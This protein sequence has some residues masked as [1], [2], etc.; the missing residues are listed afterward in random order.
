[1]EGNKKEREKV[2]EF[3][4][5]TYENVRDEKQPTEDN[6][7]DDYEEVDDGM[8]AVPMRNQQRTDRPNTDERKEPPN[9]P[10]KIEEARLRHKLKWFFSNPCQRCTYQGNTCYARVPVK[11]IVQIFKVFFISTQLMLFGTDR[12]GFVDY[13]DRH[14]LALKRL[15]LKSWITNYET[16]PYPPAVGVYGIYDINDLL[17]HIDFAVKQFYNATDVGMGSLYFIYNNEKVVPIKV[18]LTYYKERHYFP[19]ETFYLDP[20]ELKDC[21]NVLPMWETDSDNVTETNADNSTYDIAAFSEKLKQ[22]DSLKE[23]LLEVS[24]EFSYKSARLFRSIDHCYKI[25]GQI[26]IDNTDRNGQAL[27]DLVTQTAENPCSGEVDYSSPQFIQYVAIAAV[28][29]VL[30]LA[31]LF[32]SIGSIYKAVIL[33][34]ETNAFFVKY[35]HM[36]LTTSDRLEFVKFWDIVIVLNDILTISGTALKLWLEKRRTSNLTEM[37]DYCSVLLGVGCLLVWVGLVRYLTFLPKF[38]LL[39][40]TLKKSI[41]HVLRYMVCVMLLFFGFTMCGWIILGP[42]HIKF[43]TMDST[44]EC[45]F[46]I[47]QGDEMFVT[48][49]AVAGSSN[50]IWWISRLYFYIY[51]ALFTAVALNLFI[52]ILSDTYDTIKVYLCFQIN[53]SDTMEN[54]END[55]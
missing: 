19:N 2:F 47:V 28:V 7:I 46:A 55:T 44:A 34:K 30:N 35:K 8:K 23:R 36:E 15:L 13:M 18:C 48:Y 50:F 32:F 40:L 4:N 11:F 52:A 37:Y 14:N 17:E 51:I 24:I 38:N 22:S 45:L 42:Y 49:M 26:I 9:P 54:V 27:V 39:F 6:C 1:M 29:I 20:T 33:L 12:A 25:Y 41:R 21:S 5:K 10:K 53:N 3:G 16:M 43:R 31:S